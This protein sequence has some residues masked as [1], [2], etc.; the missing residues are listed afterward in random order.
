[1]L[2]EG[3]QACMAWQGCRQIRSA[4]AGEVG[5]SGVD[6]TAVAV[7]Q[8]VWAKGYTELVDLMRRHGA[9]EGTHPE[10]DCYGNGED[11]AEVREEAQRGGLRLNMKG[12]IDHL[13]P[14]MHDYKAPPPPPPRPH[15]CPPHILRLSLA[16]C[17]PV[18]LRN[19][20]LPSCRDERRMTCAL[21]DAAALY[22]A[23]QRSW[24]GVV[25]AACCCFAGLATERQPHGVAVRGAVRR[26][27]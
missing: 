13:D 7:A 15:L 25:H 14:S 6:A 23:A 22:V 5:S 19:R 20:Q 11:L 26:C 21:L 18:N 12:G 27:S 1:M 8:V 3:R 17:V 16:T 4:D 24:Q 9:R 10:I 2:L